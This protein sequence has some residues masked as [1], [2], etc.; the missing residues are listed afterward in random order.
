MADDDYSRHFPRAYAEAQK[1]KKQLKFNEWLDRAVPGLANAR[2]W[3]RPAGPGDTVHQKEE[4]DM[5]DSY[6]G[7]GAIRTSPRYVAPTARF[8]ALSP[9]QRRQVEDVDMTAPRRPGDTL[10]CGT[11]STSRVPIDTAG[12]CGAMLMVARLGTLIRA[13]ALTAAVR[14]QP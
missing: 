4:P 10:H 1:M 7:G 14:L 2:E 12:V 13:E 8:N 3:V 9:E 11:M 5:S 6:A